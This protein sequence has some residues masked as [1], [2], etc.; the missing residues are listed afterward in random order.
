MARTRL[1]PPRRGLWLCRAGV[2]AALCALLLTSAVASATDSRPPGANPPS[3]KQLNAILITAKNALSD[4]FFADSIVLVMNN[5]GPAPVG[6][7]VNRPTR[8]TVAHLFPDLKQLA[9]VPDKVYFGGPVDIET[10][11][12]LIR[13]PKQPE[14][15]VPTCDGVYLS[16]DRSLLMQ[17][18]ARAKPM[19]GLRIIAGHAG[20]APGQLEGEI[21]VGAWSLE[22]ADATKIFDRKSEHPWPSSQQPKPST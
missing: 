7:I 20:W 16:A 12:F 13:A 10:V 11:W 18:L 8:V 21:G 22:R 3:A 9:N 15:A 1:S 5:L 19:E 14:R 6:V 2:C 4:P 17:L